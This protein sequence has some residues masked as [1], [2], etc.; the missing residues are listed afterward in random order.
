MIIEIAEKNNFVY[1]VGN[2]EKIEAEARALEKLGM[3]PL[4]DGAGELPVHTAGAVGF[5]HQAQ[6]HPLKFI[7]SVAAGLN[8]YE[9]TFVK[10][11]L[12]NLAIT[13][14]GKITFQR[15]VI[16]THF[17]M[18]NK[19]GLHFMKLYQHRYLDGNVCG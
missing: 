7:Q 14:N 3:E 12:G 13:R 17:P 15:L 1:S 10:G 4:I 18:D 16:A 19:H 6:F 2:R 9:H 8:L 5:A 11:F